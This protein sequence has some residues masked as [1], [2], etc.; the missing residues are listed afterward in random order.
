MELHLGEQHAAHSQHLVQMHHLGDFLPR[1]RVKQEEGEGQRETEG[2]HLALDEIG[3][4]A[5]L[6]KVV[7]ENTLE[8]LQ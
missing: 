5:L 1:G 4:L 3:V 8:T 2:A 7:H 6:D